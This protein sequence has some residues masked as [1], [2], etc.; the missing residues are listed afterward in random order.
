MR[1]LIVML[2]LASAACRI[3]PVIQDP[4]ISDIGDRRGTRYED[5]RRA[6]RDYCKDVEAATGDEFDRCVSKATYTCVS[7]GGGE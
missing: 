1:L 5:C 3:A 7:A 2:A 4:V 6:A